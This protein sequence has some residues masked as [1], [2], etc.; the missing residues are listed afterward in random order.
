MSESFQ[1]AYKGSNAGGGRGNAG[2]KP[3]PRPNKFGSGQS[4]R[5]K[6]VSPS[7]QSKTCYKCN[8]AGHL[9]P[10]CPLRST[11]QSKPPLNQKPGNQKS[12]EWFGLCLDENMIKSDEG[13]G[14]NE[15]NMVVKL[16]GVSATDVSSLET[17]RD[18]G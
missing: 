11:Y 4:Q 14:V 16:S 7:E 3:G 1:V 13:D 15:N 17:C 9:A 10:N 6:H 18:R 8:R 5:G 2:E 12:K